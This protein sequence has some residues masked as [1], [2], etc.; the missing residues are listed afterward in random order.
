MATSK[1]L[2]RLKDAVKNS[3]GRYVPFGLSSSIAED[4]VQQKLDS[5][6]WVEV[7][8]GAKPTANN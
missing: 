4:T 8:K 6:E 1:R 5:G 3:A 2:F 7:T